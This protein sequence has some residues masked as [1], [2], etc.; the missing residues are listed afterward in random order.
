VRAHWP[1]DQS[2]P[3]LELSIGQLLAQQ[4]RARPDRVALVDGNAVPAG[5]RRWTYRELHER[6]LSVAGLL[7]ERFGPGDRVAIW[8]GNIPEW[9]IAEL[10]AALAGLVIV[11][12]NPALTA[13]E[14]RYVLNTAEVSGVLYQS[15]IPGIA[16]RLV[17]AVDRSLPDSSLL[18][19][20][21]LANA[22]AASPRLPAVTDTDPVMIQFTSGT[23]GRPKGA[24]LTHRNLVNNAY[25]LGRRLGLDPDTVW[26]NPL[27][28]F[29]VGGCSFSALGA[30]CL[31]ATHVLFSFDP[32]QAIG[33]A[34]SEG[35]TFFPGVPTM[36]FGMLEHPDFRPERVGSLRNVMVGATT[37]PPELVRRIQDALG[38]RA[39]VVFGQT[40]CS[41][42]AT[43]TFPDDSIDDKATTVG[44]PIPHTEIRI[45]DP[46]TGKIVETDD[47]GEIQIR[48]IGVMA[49]YTGMPAESAAVL[50]ADG[51][52]RT[53]DLG[54]LD[55]RGYLRIVG[56]LKDVIIRGGENIYPREIE[57]VL[58]EH[59]A[60][61]AVAVVGLPDPRY[62]EVAVAA[63]VPA[64][65]A[66]PPDPDTL[67]A[68]LQRR[69]ARFKTPAR[70]EFVESLPMTPSGKVRKFLLREQLEKRSSTGT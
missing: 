63:V 3:S 26:L 25:F 37:I 2:D 7:L 20:E 36:V 64:D 58:I 55:A 41:G 44:R 51:W 53:G 4:A 70:W 34:E 65:P 5:R 59:P 16:D 69:L 23:T 46:A 18:C 61:A 30:L 52:L 40:E 28:M 45:C 6:S 39:S 1:V 38:V 42:N 32:G 9:E 31:G 49:G 50:S 60:V 68:A 8:G 43:Q 11:T 27:P 35:A 66:R 29:H 47:V 14:A 19:L 17:G 57:D 67:V 15:T 12:V 24:V 13:D 33:L 62:G 10:A 54:S 22:P 21:E 56:R 48:G